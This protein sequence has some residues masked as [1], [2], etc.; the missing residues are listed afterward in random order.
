MFVQVCKSTKKVKHWWY[1]HNRIKMQNKAT[2]EEEGMPASV[3][4]D[5]NWKGKRKTRVKMDTLAKASIALFKMV[6]KTVPL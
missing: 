2:T 5:E 4:H 3:C 6:H 1:L